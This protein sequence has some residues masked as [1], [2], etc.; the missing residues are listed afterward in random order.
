MK[1]IIQE[2]YGGVEQLFLKNVNIPK[3]KDNQIL[4]K[5]RVANVSSGDAKI[6]TLRVNPLLRLL[7]RLV[8]GFRGP[9]SKIRGI[10]GVG[11]VVEVGV[12]VTRYQKGDVIYFINS[13]KAGCLAEYV[14]LDES[15]V[16]AHKPSM[17]SDEEAAPLAF[18]ALSAYHFINAK[19]IQKDSRVLI[20]GA[21]GSLGTYAIQLAKYYGATVTAVS[22]KKNH[23]VLKA[24]GADDVI[25]YHTTDFRDD[26]RVY[27]V[28]F[29]AVMKI[30]KRH[31]KKVLKPDGRYLSVKMPTKESSQRLI[32][33]NRMIEEGKLTT[34][35]DHVYMFEA[36]KEAHERVYSGHKVGNVVIHI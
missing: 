27:D 11:E 10:S 5:M 7:L 16:S 24:L 12:K 8:F 1:A 23:Q 31:C 20:Y 18:G 3:Y 32:E 30:N 6:N 29:D 21:S 28:I 2:R 4:V 13:M 22:S 25:D 34:Y 19:T 17:L 35:L 36:Y 33:I 14:V 15:V 9:R 26:N